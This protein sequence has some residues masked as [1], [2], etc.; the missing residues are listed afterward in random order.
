MDEN[1]LKLNELK[2]ESEAILEYDLDIE[3][4]ERVLNDVKRPKAKTLMEPTIT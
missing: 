3:E 2:K 1:K 4:L